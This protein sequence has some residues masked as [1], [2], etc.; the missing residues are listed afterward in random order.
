MNNPPVITTDTQLRLLRTYADGPTIWDAASL[1]PIV[2]ELADLG[3]TEP[4]S[5]GDAAYQLTDLGR[6]VLAMADA[7]PCR[8][9]ARH[10]AEG[11]PATRV[12][13]CGPVGW[14]PACEACAAFYARQAG[15]AAAPAA[16]PGAGS[17][18][19]S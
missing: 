9:S 6:T 8:Y 16:D 2:L 18:V 17:G 4:R 15:A 3:L 14:V 11:I 10:Q 12:I 13:D 5:P 19:G 1:A 7:E